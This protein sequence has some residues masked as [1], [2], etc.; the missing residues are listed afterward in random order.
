[1][2]RPVVT[3]LQDIYIF[4]REGSFTEGRKQ[5]SEKQNLQL[6]SV[7]WTLDCYLACAVSSKE[8]LF[9]GRYISKSG[10]AT[11]IFLYSTA[12]REQLCCAWLCFKAA[13][14]PRP[15]VTGI[16]LTPL[17]PRGAQGSRRVVQQ[18]QRGNS[19]ATISPWEVE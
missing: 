3:M 6:C 16:T 2:Y 17:H 12:A 19:R 4:R 15:P 5:F 14:P 9:C 18:V 13:V 11:I 1:M 10:H 8:H 7:V